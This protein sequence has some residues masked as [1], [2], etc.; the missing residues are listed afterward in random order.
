MLDVVAQ[1]EEVDAEPDAQLGREPLPGLLLRAFADEGEVGVASHPREG[2]QES[3]TALLVLEPCHRDHELGA[4]HPKLVAQAGAIALLESREIDCVLHHPYAV[5]RDAVGIPH[6][7][8]GMLGNG[9]PQIDE[10][11][12]E[13]SA[14]ELERL[15]EAGAGHE[16][17]V[18][19]D[20]DLRARRR[21]R[22][23]QR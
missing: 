12:Q 1:P 17:D 13:P 21:G 22:R 20:D 23:D 10:R 2:A 9:Q 8:S 5:G 11:V 3:P 18:V 14:G 6:R 7:R 19:V 15:P 4:A 16:R